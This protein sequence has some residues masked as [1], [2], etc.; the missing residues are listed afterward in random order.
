VINAIYSDKE[1]VVNILSA[2]FKDNKSVNYIVKQDKK[3]E[4][5]FKTYGIHF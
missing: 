4:H 5:S 3:K 1:L 2:A